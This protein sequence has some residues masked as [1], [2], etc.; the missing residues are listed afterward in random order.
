MRKLSVL[1]FV[2]FALP[3]FAADAVAPQERDSLLR[4]REDV[5]RSWFTHDLDRMRA[6]FPEETLA[7]DNGE[8]QWSDHGR[9]FSGAAEFAKSGGK[10]VRLEFPR[11]EIRRYGDVYILYSLYT[12]ETEQAGKRTASSG[13]VT[14]VFVKKGDR[15]INPGWH[16]SK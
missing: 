12:Y 11:T 7:F 1:L 6:Y 10:L 5:W 2:L 3:L 16:T 15:W 4:T 9:I 14:E 13:R 8:E